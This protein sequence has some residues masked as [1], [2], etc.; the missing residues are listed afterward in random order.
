MSP[1]DAELLAAARAR[2]DEARSID[3]ARAPNA[4]VGVAYYAMLFAARA[5]LSTLDIHA[6][7]HAGTWQ[8]F[9]AHFV[10]TGRAEADLVAGAE[11]AQRRREAVDYSTPDATPEEASTILADAESFVE[12]IATLLAD[13][14]R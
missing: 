14:E 10:S 5:A 6:K 4:V 3:L 2:L 13:D 9:R 7:T 1:R 11:R 8:Q 12:R